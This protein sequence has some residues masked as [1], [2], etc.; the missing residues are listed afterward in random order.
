MLALQLKGP[1]D[2]AAT[3][4]PP[5]AAEDSVAG[6]AFMV[7]RPAIRKCRRADDI[8]QSQPSKGCLHHVFGLHDRDVR[9]QNRLAVDVVELCANNRR[10]ERLNLDA[11]ADEFAG[12]GLRE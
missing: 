2:S 8:A 10:A 11:S 7:E 5:T 3:V 6:L 12:Q 4:R 1:S 9:P